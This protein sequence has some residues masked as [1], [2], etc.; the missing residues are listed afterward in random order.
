[1]REE[2]EEAPFPGTFSYPIIKEGPDAR[3]KKMK[4][5]KEVLWIVAISVALVTAGLILSCGDD[6]DGGG[7]AV[8]CQAAC[9]NL[10]ECD[11]I[12]YGYFGN[13]VKDCM[14]VC[15]DEVTGGGGEDFAEM[16]ECA[17]D[18]DCEDIMP[19]CFCKIY[20]EKLEDCDIFYWETVDDCVEECYFFFMID[21]ALC[22]IGCSSC[23]MIW[24]WCMMPIP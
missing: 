14:D 3:R 20:C 22:S 17:I 23:Y 1:V 10:E 8:D 5:R 13:T 11:W 7:A 15:E 2:P 19:D 9:E 24:D 12:T 21:T 18:A 4:G 6:D 16:F